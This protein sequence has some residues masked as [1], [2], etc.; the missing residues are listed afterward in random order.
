[1]RT[2]DISVPPRTLPQGV[3]HFHTATCSSSSKN[4]LIQQDLDFS[5]SSN[6]AAMKDFYSMCVFPKVHFT[7][8]Q[9]MGFF[10][11]NSK[12]SASG[13][14]RVFC[15]RCSYSFVFVF[16]FLGEKE[17]HGLLFQKFEKPRD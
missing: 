10:V 17:I 13:I 12:H 7:A 2:A 5:V 8:L 15:C 16:L 6:Q 11:A 1:M 9:M 14:W 3:L 4:Q